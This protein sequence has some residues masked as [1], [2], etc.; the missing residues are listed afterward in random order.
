MGICAVQAGA[1]L[2]GLL[3]DNPGMT[4]RLPV[5]QFLDKLVIRLLRVNQSGLNPR[6]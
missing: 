1:C 3:L 2:M 6:T 5:T 4:T